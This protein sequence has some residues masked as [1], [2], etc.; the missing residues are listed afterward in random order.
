VAASS[1]DARVVVI[2]AIRILSVVAGRVAATPTSNPHVSFWIEK[3]AIIAAF[4]SC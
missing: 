3:A 2:R 4:F 1:L